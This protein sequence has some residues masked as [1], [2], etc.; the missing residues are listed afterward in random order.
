MLQAAVLGAVDF[1]NGR[2]FDPKWWKQLRVRLQ[3]LE[4]QQQ[5]RYWELLQ[6]HHVSLLSVPNLKQDVFAT[7]NKAAGLYAEQIHDAL[8]PW[9]A[10]PRQAESEAAGKDL[11]QAWIDIWGDPADPEVQK[12]IDDTVAALLAKIPTPEDDH[13]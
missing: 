12:R 7:A 3:G 11:R 2:H 8:F 13:G 5:I 6:R 1:R 9:T 4:W 10:A